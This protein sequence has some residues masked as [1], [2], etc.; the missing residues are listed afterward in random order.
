V[1]SSVVWGLYLLK[2]LI[3]ILTLSRKLP[4]YMGL[5]LLMPTLSPSTYIL[6][7]INHGESPI[8]KGCEHM[9]SCAPG[10]DWLRDWYQLTFSFHWSACRYMPTLSWS[11]VHTYRQNLLIGE[12]PLLMVKIWGKRPKELQF[13]LPPLGSILIQAHCITRKI[14][15][16]CT[17]GHEN[18]CSTRKC[19]E[20]KEKRNE[21]IK[22]ILV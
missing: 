21:H 16:Q 20:K 6:Q 7:G 13:L 9:P 12:L 18:D 10:W 14:G 3:S 8:D 22:C 1:V 4:F 11:P 17:L 15:L 5:F 19:I 2:V